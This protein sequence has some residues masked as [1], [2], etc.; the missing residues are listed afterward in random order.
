MN[1]RYGLPASI[2][3]HSYLSRHM[4]VHTISDVAIFTRNETTNSVLDV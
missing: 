2:D 1:L 3:T 4:T